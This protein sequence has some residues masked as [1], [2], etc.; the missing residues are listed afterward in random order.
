MNK[1]TITT[2]L[3]AQEI[4]DYLAFR[5]KQLDNEVRAPHNSK[6]AIERHKHTVEELHHIATRALDL[7]ELRMF[8]C[9]FGGCEVSREMRSYLYPEPETPEAL[10]KSIPSLTVQ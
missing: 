7:P 9:P 5:H 6:A 8:E 4:V 10:L 2:K 3:T 1:T